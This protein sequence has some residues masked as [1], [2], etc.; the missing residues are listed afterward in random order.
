LSIGKGEF[1]VCDDWTAITNGDSTAKV[2][3][4]TRPA[5]P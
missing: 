5:T 2:V 4:C 1:V 3:S